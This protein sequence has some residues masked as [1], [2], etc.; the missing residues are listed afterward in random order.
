MDV[1]AKYGLCPEATV[2]LQQ[3]WRQCPFSWGWL[4]MIMLHHMA[5]QHALQPAVI[6]CK[7]VSLSAELQ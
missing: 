6:H 3:L 5:L 7:T 1:R 2:W 4:A